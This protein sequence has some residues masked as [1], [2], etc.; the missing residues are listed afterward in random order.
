MVCC[1]INP[2]I[3]PKTVPIVVQSSEEDV[4]I[5]ADVIVVTDSFAILVR[6]C[7][8]VKSVVIKLAL[9]VALYCVFVRIGTLRSVILLVQDFSFVNLFILEIAKTV[10]KLTLAQR[11]LGSVNGVPAV[12]TL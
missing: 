5:D 7:C 6:C 12:E 9:I 4:S 1:A 8:T 11:V 3:T 10:Q 2:I